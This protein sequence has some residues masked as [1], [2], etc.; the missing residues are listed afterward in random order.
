MFVGQIL[1]IVILFVY[2]DFVDKVQF[3]DRVNV[4]GIY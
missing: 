3:G 4:I 2:N 1:Y